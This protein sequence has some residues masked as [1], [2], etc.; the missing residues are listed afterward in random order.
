MWTWA[1]Q[2]AGECKVL[3]GSGLR[4]LLTAVLDLR[5]DPASCLLATELEVRT[6]LEFSVEG[7]RH[8]QL[9]FEQGSASLATEHH[10]D[11]EKSGASWPG[12]VV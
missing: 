8:W 11:S 10:S 6:L 2:A 9:S 3:S 5:M 1:L 12:N 7:I 4:E